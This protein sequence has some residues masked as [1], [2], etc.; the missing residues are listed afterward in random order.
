MPHNLQMGEEGIL[1]VIL[2]GDLD[3]ASINA[4]IKDLSPYLNAATETDPI[5]L[6][7]DSSKVRKYS[8]TARK[9]LT[10]LNRDL[11]IGN[12]AIIG[13]NRAS[14]VL[15]SFILKATGRENISFFASE[16]EA[17][18]WLQSNHDNRA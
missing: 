18:A 6:I 3:K 17:L 14:R 2:N 10:D 1:R 4:F 8:S 5:H 13:A 16:K 15:S 12:Q 7:N 9:T 11:R